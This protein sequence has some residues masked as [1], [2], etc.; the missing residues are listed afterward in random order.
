MLRPPSPSAVS[1]ERETLY[2]ALVERADGKAAVSHARERAARALDALLDTNLYADDGDP[3]A[4]VIAF[5]RSFRALVRAYVRAEPALSEFA[6]PAGRIVDPDGGLLP[7]QFTY[8]IAPLA[9]I[10]IV[11]QMALR[12]LLERRIERDGAVLAKFVLQELARQA[13]FTAPALRRPRSLSELRPIA[14]T[15]RGRGRPAGSFAINHRMA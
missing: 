13:A 14:G 5:L 1:K 9:S 10:G 6:Y 3:A 2:L 12:R 11:G 7:P 8:F 4:N 15:P